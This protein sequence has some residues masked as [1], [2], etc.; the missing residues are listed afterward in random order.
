[1]LEHTTLDDFMRGLYLDQESSVKAKAKPS[2]LG[3]VMTGVGLDELTEETSGLKSLKFEDT[4]A[5]MKAND[6]QLRQ[7]A[8]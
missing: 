3:A 1:M 4:E 7:K 6:D 5:D 2:I 8:L